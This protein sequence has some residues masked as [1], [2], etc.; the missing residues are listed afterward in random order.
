MGR[1]PPEI[2]GRTGAPG[3]DKEAAGV[4]RGMTGI[5]GMRGRGEGAVPEEGVGWGVGGGAGWGMWEAWF[6]RW[7]CGLALRA[8][9]WR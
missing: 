7:G 1:V 4:R 6:R 2:G 5:G 9:L 8:L 3:G